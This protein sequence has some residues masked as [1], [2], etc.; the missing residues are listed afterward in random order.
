VNSKIKSFDSVK[1]DL[2]KDSL[3]YLDNVCLMAKFEDDSIANIQYLSNGDS[4]FSKEKIEIFCEQS[5]ITIDDFK[6]SQ[7]ISDGKIRNFN[8][9]V[10]DKGQENCLKEYFFNLVK[11]KTSL[12]SFEDIIESAMISIK[13]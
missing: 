4:A 1:L 12:I 10:Q 11:N 7:F 9:S 3:D 6:N 2:G 13:S 5:I 8:L